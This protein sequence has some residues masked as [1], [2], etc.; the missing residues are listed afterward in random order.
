MIKHRIQNGIDQIITA[1]GSDHAFVFADARPQRLKVT[2]CFFLKRENA[3]CVLACVWELVLAFLS[4]LSQT[5][6]LLG[7]FDNRISRTRIDAAQIQVA[8]RE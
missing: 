8:L 6:V 7:T 5:L 4:Q 1:L 2:A 3:F